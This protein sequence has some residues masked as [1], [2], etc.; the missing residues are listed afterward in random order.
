[1]ADSVA[2]EPWDNDVAA[3]FIRLLAHLNTRW[4]R[5]GRDA[6]EACEVVLSRSMAMQ[7]TGSGSLARARSILDRL[8]THVTLVVDRQGMATLVRW[9]KFAEF[10]KLP[11]E[12]GAEVVA[13]P[14]ELLPPPQDAPA[15]ARRKTEEKTRRAS[16]SPR[17]VP[18][19][20]LSRVALL[21]TSIADSVPGERELSPAQVLRWGTELDRLHRIDG[22]SWEQIDAVIMWL[23]SH[24]RGEFRWGLVI[25]SARKLRQ[26]FPRL[27]AEMTQPKK[28]NGGY[29]ETP[30]TSAPETPYDV[31]FKAALVRLTEGGRET[32]I[33]VAE[34]EAEIARVEGKVPE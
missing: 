10:Q 18:P 28:A 13:Q 14:S 9:P 25:R 22:W 16:R 1:V 32:P 2:Y 23:P 26:H 30:D 20:A 8:A 7:L 17:G 3:A 34:I 15:P 33:P 5:E 11:S 27:H 4:A 29:R 12:S 24:D 6:S 31:A 19:E 21:R